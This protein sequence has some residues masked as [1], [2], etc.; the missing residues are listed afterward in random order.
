MC[1]EGKIK[2]LEQQ[3]K[4]ITAKVV[5]LG[6]KLQKGKLMSGVCVHACMRACMSVCIMCSVC[7]PANLS[8]LFPV[9]TLPQVAQPHKVP[10]GRTDAST[11]TLPY[12]TVDAGTQWISCRKGSDYD[13]LNALS[14]V[15]SND[16]PSPATW[17]MKCAALS[18]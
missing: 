10:T 6:R 3:N 7:G 9:F 14:D 16:T 2:H 12:G 18:K 17:E 5:K 13:T 11:N 1:A 15:S 8:L 4:A